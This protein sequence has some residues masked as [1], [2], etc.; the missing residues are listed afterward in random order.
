MSFPYSKT[1]NIRKWSTKPQT[2][3]NY[4]FTVMNRSSDVKTVNPTMPNY[5]GT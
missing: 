5:E 3:V 1:S 4:N 2:C